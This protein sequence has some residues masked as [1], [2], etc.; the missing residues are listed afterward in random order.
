[1]KRILFGLA[2]FLISITV[3]ACGQNDNNGSTNQDNGTQNNAVDQ[4][5]DQNTT[6]NNVADDTS[7]TDDSTDD[8]VQKME[9]LE[10][11][12]FELDV[13]YKDD[14]DY[15]AD[16]DL[17]F[18]N[19][20]VSAK[21]E[22]DLNGVKI[23]GDGAFDEIYPLVEQLTIDQNTSKEDVIQQVLDVFDLPTDYDEFELE[24]KF[25]DGTKK[26]YDDR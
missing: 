4:N 20:S 22:D 18:E 16:L 26:E 11:I 6:D 17:E 7:Q 8:K 24:I 14:Q 25:K 5:Q 15:E 2:M 23:A 13:K 19:N 3:V 9:N 1:M 21:L 10:Y 12:D